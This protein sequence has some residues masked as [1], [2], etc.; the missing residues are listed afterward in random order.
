M[1]DV[2]SIAVTLFIARSKLNGNGYGGQ[3]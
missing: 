1:M 3:T 2:K